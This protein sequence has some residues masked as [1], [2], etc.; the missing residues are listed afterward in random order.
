MCSVTFRTTTSTEVKMTASLREKLRYTV[1]LTSYLLFL[2][3]FTGLTVW[4]IY[5]SAL[6]AIQDVK[7][8][9]ATYPL[10]VAL[11]REQ[12]HHHT[13]NETDTISTVGGSS[14]KQPFD[15]QLVHLVGHL[16]TPDQVSDSVF[17]YSYDHG[18]LLLLNRDVEI[19]YPKFIPGLA[20]SSDRY[21]YKWLHDINGTCWYGGQEEYKLSIPFSVESYIAGSI[22]LGWNYSDGSNNTNN[23]SR[24]DTIRLWS[25]DIPIR[26]TFQTWNDAPPEK[27]RPIT[28]ATNITNTTLQY[29]RIY[30]IESSTNRFIY[31]PKSFSTTTFLICGDVRITYSAIPVP[32][33]AVSI[34]ASLSC[35]T[36]ATDRNDTTG[37]RSNNTSSHESCTIRS[38]NTNDNS[39][40]RQDFGDNIPFH[41]LERGNFTMDEMYH[42][43]YRTTIR[44]TTKSFALACTIGISAAFL[45]IILL[46]IFCENGAV[47]IYMQTRNNSMTGGKCAWSNL[48]LILLLSTITSFSSGLFLFSMIWIVY[49]TSLSIM[50]PLAIISFIT[51]IYLYSLH[52]NIRA[53]KDDGTSNTLD[54]DEQ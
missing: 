4:R 50:I 8:L 47:M 35:T 40:N 45:H 32:A 49:L 24:Y 10:V 42:R 51:T 19:Y 18:D 33:T 38:Y 17:S 9:R 43:A 28:M 2:I 7:I 34:V 3:F 16:Y 6:T 15:H 37:S 22:Y 31:R 48:G 36:D 25:E 5:E 44:R 20:Y 39:T 53:L 30:N 23:S 11:N 52:F 26:N 29:K 46:M 1:G 27:P 54:S 41:L 14:G 12:F 21:E 13:G